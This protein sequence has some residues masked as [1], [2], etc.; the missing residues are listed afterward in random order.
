MELYVENGAGKSCNI[1]V[2]NIL[3]YEARKYDCKMV[4]FKLNERLFLRVY[5]ISYYFEE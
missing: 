1:V 5:I 2:L 4:Q 3:S